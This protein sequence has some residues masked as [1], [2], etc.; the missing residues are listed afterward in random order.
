MIFWQINVGDTKEHLCNQ[1]SAI[2]SDEER[3]MLPLFVGGKIVEKKSPDDLLEIAE[4]Q[5]G[6][7]SERVIKTI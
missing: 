7:E 4:R 5:L 6:E 1:V 2:L 3:T